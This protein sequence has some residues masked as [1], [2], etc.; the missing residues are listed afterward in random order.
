[1]CL[2]CLRE[3]P[4]AGPVPPARDG[5]L[6]DGAYGVGEV[7]RGGRGEPG[8]YRLE[9]VPGQGGEQVPL[10]GYPDSASTP[11]PTRE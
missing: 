1:M 7:F 6:V 8:G 5:P 3:L 9:L 11:V 10:G 4:P 2:P